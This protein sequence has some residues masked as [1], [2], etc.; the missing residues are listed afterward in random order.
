MNNFL[1]IIVFLF[2][3]VAIVTFYFGLEKYFPIL[4]LKPIEKESLSSRAYAK[5]RLFDEFRIF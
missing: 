4:K 5:V 1:G 2:I 3:M